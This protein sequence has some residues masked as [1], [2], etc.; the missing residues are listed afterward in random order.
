MNHF[1][2]VHASFSVECFATNITSIRFLSSMYSQMSDKVTPPLKTPWTMRAIIIASTS[3]LRGIFLN[4]WKTTD[5]LLLAELM[6]LAGQNIVVTQFLNQKLLLIQ[7][8]TVLCFIVVN[9]LSDF[10]IKLI[11]TGVVIYDLLASQCSYRQVGVKFK[12]FSRTPCCAY[13]WCST[14]CTK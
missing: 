4:I 6:S 14:C 11:W 9:L 2:P 1:V 5:N 7:W 12:D 3:K 13:I 8:V 10:H